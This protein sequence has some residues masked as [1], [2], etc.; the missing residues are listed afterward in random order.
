MKPC[1]KAEFEAVF[2]LTHLMELYG[3]YSVW[4]KDQPA[5]ARSLQEFTQSLKDQ[6]HSPLGT[7][8][9]LKPGG[10]VDL[11]NVPYKALFKLYV[12]YGS[13][14]QLSQS[15]FI[16]VFKHIMQWRQETNCGQAPLGSLGIS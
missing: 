15:R 6:G 5:A 8:L 9:R 12:K 10:M 7:G 3:G 14:L 1:S 11:S 16:Q 2:P 4:S 13:G